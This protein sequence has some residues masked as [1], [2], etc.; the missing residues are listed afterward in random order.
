MIYKAP[1]SIKN[2]GHRVNRIS[3]RTRPSPCRN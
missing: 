1:R 3:M 2:Q